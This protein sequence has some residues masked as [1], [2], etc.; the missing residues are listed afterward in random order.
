M[1][2]DNEIQNLTELRNW[3]MGHKKRLD[4]LNMSIPEQSITL[5][6]LTTKRLKTTKKLCESKQSKLEL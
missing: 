3:L 1:N 5:L 2:I 6:D 4:I